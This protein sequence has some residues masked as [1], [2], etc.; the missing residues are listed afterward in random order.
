MVIVAFKL[1]H[2]RLASRTL[3]CNCGHKACVTKMIKHFLYK[4]TVRTICCPFL[5]VERR[6]DNVYSG[7]GFVVR[8]RREI[9]AESTDIVMRWTLN[10]LIS[11]FGCPWHSHNWCVADCSGTATGGVLYVTGTS[12]C[13]WRTTVTEK[14][15]C[16]CQQGIKS[17]NPY[18][19]PQ[20]KK[21][22]A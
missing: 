13:H 3:K 1:H 19:K 6:H 15:Q 21:M 8:R 20:V 5:A 18:T 14:L 2:N 16:L 12:S 9:S 7:G 4:S 11:K 17:S 10:C 22:E